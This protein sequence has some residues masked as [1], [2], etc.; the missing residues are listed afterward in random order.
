MAKK[1]SV[2]GD[3]WE[4]QRYFTVKYAGAFLVAQMVKNLPTMPETEV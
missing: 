4:K 3:S 1:V 2:S